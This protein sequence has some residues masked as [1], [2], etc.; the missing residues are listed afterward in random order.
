MKHRVVTTRR[1][2]FAAL[3]AAGGAAA[4]AGCSGSGSGRINWSL[5]MNDTALLI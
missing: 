1:Q 2:F 5:L 3:A 4:L